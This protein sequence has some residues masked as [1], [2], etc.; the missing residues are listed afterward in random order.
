MRSELINR[1]KLRECTHIKTKS[2]LG[3][4]T[5]L[6]S[7]PGVLVD[8]APLKQIVTALAGVNKGSINDLKKLIDYEQTLIID[9][10]HEV[11]NQ[12]KRFVTKSISKGLVVMTAG[13][14][15]VFRFYELEL[16][17]LSYDESVKLVNKH[18][19]N[20]DLSRVIVS[21]VGGYPGLLMQAVRKALARD[22]LMTVKGFN[23]F[24]NS[25]NLSVKRID[26]LKPVNLSI[27]SGL[28]ISIRYLLYTQHQFN[29]GYT[30]AM[31]AYAL[32]TIG[33][34]SKKK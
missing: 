21:E 8:P 32:I 27:I 34:V 16:K 6:K 2:G 25:I 13:L 23:E 22:D 18:L 5:F 4:T 26:L 3:T 24:R 20:K 9:D 12:V 33:R 14:R 29:Y 19:R 10:V 30:V 1:I 31:I 7:L 15:N 28:L 11:T 17:P